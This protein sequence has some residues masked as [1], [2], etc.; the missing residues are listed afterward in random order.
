MSFICSIAF[1]QHEG[2]SLPIQR[3]RLYEQ[4]VNAMLSLTIHVP[5]LRPILSDIAFYIHQQSSSDLIHEEKMTEICIDSIRM[6]LD[7]QIDDE[8]NMGTIE[9]QATEIVRIFREDIGILA[10]Q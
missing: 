7:K 1:Q 4:I 9:R 10:A 8:D 5:K 3:I 6:Y 2:S